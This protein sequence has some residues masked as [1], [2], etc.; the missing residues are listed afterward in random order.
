MG[1]P[2]VT[3]LGGQAGPG[4]GSTEQGALRPWARLSG[5]L[6]VLSCGR[7][8]QAPSLWALQVWPRAWAGQVL[9]SWLP[10]LL[11]LTQDGRS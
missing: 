3:R 8:V 2:R 6:G 7:L 5:S 1:G 11:L 4:R 10:G 9:R